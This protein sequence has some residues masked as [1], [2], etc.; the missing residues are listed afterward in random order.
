MK[1]IEIPEE[2][3]II[4]EDWKPFARYPYSSYLYIFNLITMYKAEI[5]TRNRLQDLLGCPDWVLDN[6]DYN[7]EDIES[8]VYAVI[9]WDIDK[10]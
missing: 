6:V 5:L 7:L 3:L 9:D 1:T 4:S 8:A 2:N 10:E